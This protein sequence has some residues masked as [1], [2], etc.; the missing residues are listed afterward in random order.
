MSRKVFC[1]LILIEPLCAF[2]SGACGASATASERG[3]SSWW[4]SGCGGLAL[5]AFRTYSRHRYYDFMWVRVTKVWDKLSSWPWF[6]GSE[7]S[8]KSY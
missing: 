7:R 5:L 1:F 6:A 8:G 3:N 2:P 4:E